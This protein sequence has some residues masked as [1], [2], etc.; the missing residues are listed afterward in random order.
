VL[1]C[2]HSS[3]KGKRLGTGNSETALEL[4]GFNYYYFFPD[5]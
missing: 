4:Y 1:D 5:D 2:W 3:W